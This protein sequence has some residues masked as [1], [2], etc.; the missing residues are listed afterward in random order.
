MKWRINPTGARGVARPSPKLFAAWALAA[1]FATALMLVCFPESGVVVAGAQERFAGQW[2]VEYKPGSEK[3]QLTLSFR[4]E[5]TDAKGGTHT[6][7]WNTTN[8]I[9]P[10]KLQGLTREQAFSPGG[11]NVRFQL[12]REAGTFN[13]E[14]WFRNGKAP[15]ISTRPR[16]R[17]AR[18]GPTRH[19]QPDERQMFRSRRP[20]SVS[21]WLTS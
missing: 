13:C 21:R 9:E 20:T 12:R 17:F 10:A 4:E 18:A 19:R 5:R 1:L 2:L 6:N 8:D 3:V 14:G 15:A 7:S 11:A 16:R